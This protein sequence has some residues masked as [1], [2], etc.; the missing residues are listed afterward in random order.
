[1]KLKGW[2]EIPDGFD[3]EIVFDSGPKW[4]EFLA[5]T[6][7]FERFAY[8]IGVNKGLIYLRVSEDFKSD[9][10]ITIPGWEIKVNPKSIQEKFLEGS[11][12]FLSS[13]SSQFKNSKKGSPSF[14]LTRWG[15][16]KSTRKWVHKRNGTYSYY[17]SRTCPANLVEGL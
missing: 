16:T 5:L 15:F 4:L 12:A 2:N 7:F 8:P 3:L 1:M 6:P 11:L 9:S 14:S 10:S 13:S 17:K